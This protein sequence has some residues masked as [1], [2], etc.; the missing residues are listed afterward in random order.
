MVCAKE[1]SI[2]ITKLSGSNPLLK[3][4]IATAYDI[5]TIAENAIMFAVS[6]RA[7]KLRNACNFS[8]KQIFNTTRII[9]YPN[10]K[11][12]KTVTHSHEE[13]GD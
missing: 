1:L 2:G 9:K 4:K 8:M 10:N 11:K 7:V 13:T 5:K 6:K 3:A 12:L